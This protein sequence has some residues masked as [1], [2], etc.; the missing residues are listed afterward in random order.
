[1]NRCARRFLFVLSLVFCL[2]V[3]ADEL[4]FPTRF[5]WGK[6]VPTDETVELHVK[7]VPEDRVVSFPR[8][9]SPFRRIYLQ[10]APTQPI[11]FRPGVSQWQIKYPKSAKAPGKIIIET[12]GRPGMLIQP[13]VCES[14]EEGMFV[15]P[16]HHAVVH[17]TLLRYEPQPHKNVIGYWANEDDWCEWWIDVEDPL[18]YEVQILQGCGKGHGGSEVEISVGKSKLTFEVEDTGHFQKFK[19]RRLGFLEIR[20]PGRHSVKVRALHKAKGAVM[21]IRQIRLVPPEVARRSKKNAG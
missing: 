18:D 3:A 17:G 9:N 5:S 20:R 19:A 6:I 14:D 1:M 7:G 13:H 4:P 12:V 8:L 10:S 21:D 16:A 15:L 2:P 11:D